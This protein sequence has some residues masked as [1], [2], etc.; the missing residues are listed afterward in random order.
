MTY[1]FKSNC[2]KVSSIAFFMLIFQAA[3]SQRSLKNSKEY[4][5]GNFK[6][7]NDVLNNQQKLLGKDYAALVW[8]DTIVFKKET[9]NFSART[10]V[11][12]GDAS[13]W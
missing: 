3:F 10:Q 2:L 5:T 9:P 13:S 6:E 8:T 4:S 12:I 7:L 11:E 1:K